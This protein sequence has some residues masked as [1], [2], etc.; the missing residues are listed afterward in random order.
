MM[1]AENPQDGVV[2]MVLDYDALH[3][4]IES[5]GWT[6]VRLAKRMGL[7][8]SYLFRVLR[9]ERGIGKKFIAGLMKICEEEGLEFKD[10]ISL[11]TE[12]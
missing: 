6:E 5:R 3:S 10:F 12:K 1:S 7:N 4:L 2:P 9:K 11:E 8:Y